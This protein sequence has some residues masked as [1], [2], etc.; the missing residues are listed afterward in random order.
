MKVF[1]LIPV[2]AFHASW[3][4]SLYN[5]EAIVRAED[6][7]QARTI[8]DRE[9]V[10]PGRQGGETIVHPWYLKEVVKAEEY[11]DPRYPSMGEPGLL[12]PDP[13]EW[14]L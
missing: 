11:F 3:G 10:N 8:A 4:R 6:E 5:W 12:F 14:S 9:F 13:E 1:K 2:D 7:R